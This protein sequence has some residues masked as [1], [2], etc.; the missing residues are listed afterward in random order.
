M[1]E[2]KRDMAILATSGREWADRTKRLAARVPY[3]NIFSQQLI[4]RINGGWRIIT[5]NGRAVL[6]FMEARP[7]PTEVKLRIDGASAESPKSVL[8]QSL[9]IEGDRRRHEL[10]QRRRVL[11]NQRRATRS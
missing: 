2:L 5:E 10:R 11:D 8:T 7:L 9:P 1:T 6:D 3:L 4:E